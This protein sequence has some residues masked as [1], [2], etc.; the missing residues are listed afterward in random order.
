MQPLLALGIVL[1]MLAV[2]RAALRGKAGR[3]VGPG[4]RGIRVEASCAL[5]PRQR[6]HVVA[7]DG[8]RLLVGV[9][10]QRVQLLRRLAPAA[11]V[12]GERAAAPEGAAARSGGRLRAVARVLGAVAPAVA[13]LLLPALAFAQG[14]TPSGPTLALDL[15]AAAAP[16]RIA[17]T[18]EIVALLTLLSVAP[19]VL[20]MATCFTRVVIVLALLRQ[21]LG[22]QQLPPNQ[23]LIGLAL[24]ITLFVMAPLGER[25]QSEALDPYVAR[26]IS[27]EDAAARTG[28]ALRGYLLQHTRER[29]LA[30]FLEI[31]GQPEPE[32]PD[33]VSLFTLLP[34]F[35]ISELRTAFEIGFS[36]FL[37]FLVIDL[38]VASL[39]ISMQMIVLPP[40][41]VSLPFKLMLFVLVDGWNLIVGSL[42][43][44]LGGGIAG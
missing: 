37:P 22:V 16:E 31:A 28:A 9:T 19:S 15:G 1:A 20:L 13:A 11:E 2:L 36:I 38:V 25:I 17:G 30:L 18:L 26:A 21:A 35:M 42:V 40:M 4:G 5:G 34:A 6:L 44:G 41:I 14:A 29:D 10:D 43:R 27:A 24:A 33:A 39:L 7:V 12:A 32:T 3:R 23:V 8:E